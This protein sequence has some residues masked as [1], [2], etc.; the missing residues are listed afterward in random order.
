MVL[1]SDGA[2]RR[3]SFS[4]QAACAVS[5]TEGEASADLGANAPGNDRIVSVLRLAGCTGSRQTRNVH[6]M[7]SLGFSDVLAMEMSNDR[8]PQAP[9]EPACFSA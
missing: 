6:Q 1:I 3:E 5:G 8:P 4:S 9:D 2:D 7:A